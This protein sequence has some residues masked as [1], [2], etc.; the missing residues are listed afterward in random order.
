[1]SRNIE[2]TISLDGLIEGRLPGIEDAEE[3]LRSWTRFVEGVNLGF[4]LEVKGGSFS[5]L[6]DNAARTIDSIGPDPIQVISSAMKELIKLFPPPERQRVMS[7]VRSVE[8]RKGQERQTLY[9]FNAIGDVQTQQRN[10]DVETTPPPQPLTRREKIRMAVSTLLILALMAGLS[11][12]IVPWR[13]WFHSVKNDVAGF[14]ASKIDVDASAFAP[15]I[16]VDST[17][18]RGNDLIVRLKV[19]RGALPA[20]QSTANPSTTTN[21]TTIPSAPKPA[22]PAALDAWRLGYA[23][24]EY[25][26]EKGEFVSF[27]QIWL[28][29]LWNKDTMEIRI[30]LSRERRPGKIVIT[31]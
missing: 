11:A 6:A 22:P 10:I 8:Y 4:S 26:D 31:Y 13:S 1:M 16:H 18:V 7:T 23:H 9:A 19:D 17:E 27:M 2:G 20:P 12:F 24:L 30:P 3:K 28:K 5:I 21:P 25:F 14:D 15:L 29:G